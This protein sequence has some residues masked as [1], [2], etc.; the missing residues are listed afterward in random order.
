MR[1]RVLSGCST[2]ACLAAKRLGLRRVGLIGCLGSDF[3][4]RFHSDMDR[5]GIDIIHVKRS[6]ETAGFKLIYDSRGNR[7]LDVLGIAGTIQPEDLPA[8]CFDA[9]AILFAPILQEVDV[10]L[11]KFVRQHSEAKTFVDPQG[12]LR[13]VETN[14]RIRWRCS[15]EKAVALTQLVDVIKPNEYEAEVLTQAE[16]P[17]T[18]TRLLSEW[19]STISIVTLAEKGSL[20]GKGRNIMR[21]PPYK[22]V[23]V[24]PT[25]AGDVY[26]GSFIT[27]YFEERSL[28]ECAVFA[29][30]AAS[31]KIE[32]SG[33]DFPMTYAEVSRRVKELLG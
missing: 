19:G 11:M 5:Y 33:P 32:H 10:D 1:G 31:M 20:M 18:A 22:T 13:D 21:I 16:N 15:R 8:S 9:K 30:A 2:N 28:F 23:A 12:L 27:K 29:S 3:E 25:G 17:Y 26:I 24:D 4:S 14:G 7:T 6:E